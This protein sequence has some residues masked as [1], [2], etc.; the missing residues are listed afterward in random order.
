[1]PYEVRINQRTAIVELLS[2]KQEQLLVLVDGREYRLDVQQVGAGKLSILHNNKSYNIELIEREG[3]R[4]FHVN[5]NTRTFEVDIIDAEAKYLANRRKGQEEEGESIIRAPIPGKVVR[6][7]VR[8]GDTVE[9]GQTVVILSAMKMESE[10]KAGR[11]GTVRE[12]AVEEGQTVD[13]R[14]SLVAIDYLQE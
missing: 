3:P 1:M 14:Q 6:V 12:V 7:L 5:T 11:S 4:R 13:A 9:A 2:R 10:F 8:E